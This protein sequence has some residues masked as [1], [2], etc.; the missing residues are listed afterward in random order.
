MPARV[1]ALLVVRPD[2]R[3]PAAHHLRLTLA[4]LDAQTRPVD[5]LTI[6]VCGNDSLA[7]EAARTA[8]S[9]TLVAAPASTSFAAALAMCDLDQTADAIWLLAQDTAPEPDALLR[10]AGTLELAP[11]AAF[12]APKL[13]RADDRSVIE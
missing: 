11:S 6:V 7:W 4:A 2:G 9:A 1:H 3:T 13:V 10:L 8:E 5:V 12:V